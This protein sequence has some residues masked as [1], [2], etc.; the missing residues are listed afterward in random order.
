MIHW[1]IS[2]I[3]PEMITLSSVSEIEIANFRAWDYEHM[4]HMLKPVVTMET[5]FSI[6]SN[7]SNSKNIL[8]NWVKELAEFRMTPNQIYKAKML[9]KAYQYFIIFSCCLHGQDIIETF[10]PIWVI[11][12]DQLASEGKSC[13]WSDMLAHMLKE[14]VTRAQQPPKG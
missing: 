10:L 13:N 2:H 9:R 11:A 6:P 4:Y 5:P 1:I 7:N 12:L 8:K 14:Q 3:N